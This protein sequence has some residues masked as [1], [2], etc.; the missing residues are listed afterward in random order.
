LASP[1]S[2]TLNVQVFVFCNQR[3]LFRA[4]KPKN[5]KTESFIFQNVASYTFQVFKALEG[6][7]FGIFFASHKLK[8]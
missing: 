6:L 8:T 4:K 5:Q 3:Q 7:Q 1:P 2:D